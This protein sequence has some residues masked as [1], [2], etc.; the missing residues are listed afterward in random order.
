MGVGGW[1][2]TENFSFLAIKRDRHTA[3]FPMGIEQANIISETLGTVP[4]GRVISMGQMLAVLI[5]ITLTGSARLQR[6]LRCQAPTLRVLLPLFPSLRTALRVSSTGTQNLGPCTPALGQPCPQEAEHR[7]GGLTSGPV[8]RETEN[9][10]LCSCINSSAKLGR[11][12]P[13][14]GI[15]WGLIALASVQHLARGPHVIRAHLVKTD[16]IVVAGCWG[17]RERRKR[18]PCLSGQ[19]CWPGGLLSRPPPPP[20][21]IDSKGLGPQGRV[22]AHRCRLTCRPLPAPPRPVA[23][24]DEDGRCLLD[25]IW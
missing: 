11:Q 25:V 22:L 7:L 6:L 23:M 10:N 2:N 24:D 5:L 13:P 16:V 21:P 15:P 20:V 9:H 12:D 4:G 8:S 19:S 17:N 14:R 18:Q 3:P 1:A